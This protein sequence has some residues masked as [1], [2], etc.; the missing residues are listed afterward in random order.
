MN[1]VYNKLHVYYYPL[2]PS[3][4]ATFSLLALGSY[5]YFAGS[6]Y[7]FTY[8]SYKGY[9]CCKFNQKYIKYSLS[10]TNVDPTNFFVLHLNIIDQLATPCFIPFLANTLDI[11]L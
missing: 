10:N 2:V 3:K 1:H 7:F 6:F 8:F 4:V 5:H 11:H 9:V